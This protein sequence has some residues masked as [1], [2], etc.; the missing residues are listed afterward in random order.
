[1]GSHRSPVSRCPYQGHAGPFL[2]GDLTLG[3]VSTG[4]RKYHFERQSTVQRPCSLAAWTCRPGV[5]SKYKKGR[6]WISNYV[7]AANVRSSLLIQRFSADARLRRARCGQRRDLCLRAIWVLRCVWQ[8]SLALGAAAHTAKALAWLNFHRSIWLLQFCDNRRHLFL[9]DK[10]DLGC[11]G[12]F[13]EKPFHWVILYLFGQLVTVEFTAIS[14]IG[15]LS[16]EGLRPFTTCVYIYIHIYLH[17]YIYTIHV[18]T[19]IYNI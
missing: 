9:C 7:T 14:T 11:D 12:N 17:I 4:W 13:V 15:S 16:L 10:T 3:S 5:G 8:G 18:H 6:V 1:M 19:D 2:E